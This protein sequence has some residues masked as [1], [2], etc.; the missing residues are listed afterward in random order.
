M[1]GTSVF[2]PARGPLHEPWVNW[3]TGP[4]EGPLRLVR[5]AILAAN[6]QYPA[7]AV[8]RHA[9]ARRCLR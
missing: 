9:I 3:K 6:P 4:A 5:A 1:R 8:S 7:V 2:T